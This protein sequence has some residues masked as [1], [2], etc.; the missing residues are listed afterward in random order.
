MM[1]TKDLTLS[2]LLAGLGIVIG[3]LE[4]FMPPLFVFAPGA[5]LGL[6]NIVSLV[7]LYTLPYK[8]ALTV[9]LLRV[10]LTALIT[11]TA[12]SFIYSLAGALF[13]FFVMT[14]V[15]QLGPDRVS[16]IGV[17]VMGGI[18][19]NFGQLTIAAITSNSWL[20]Y[21]YLPFMSIVGTLAGFIVGIAGNFLVAELTKRQKGGR[22]ETSA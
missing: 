16:I 21:N 20:T 13:S 3:I 7:A 18:S 5:K 6:S 19:H 2:A 9:V 15:K 22:K 14:L 12:N 4:S 1:K 17:S 11:G 8:Q 10:T